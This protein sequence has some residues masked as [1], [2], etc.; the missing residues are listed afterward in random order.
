MDS[1]I[2]AVKEVT[3]IGS[4]LFLIDKKKQ[5]VAHYFIEHREYNKWA[6]SIYQQGIVQVNFWRII[7]GQQNILK[8]SR[9]K[10]YY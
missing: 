4:T 5:K 3:I 1:N 6:L 10:L 9:V 7:K 2:T 8:L